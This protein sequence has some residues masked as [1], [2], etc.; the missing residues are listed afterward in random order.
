MNLAKGLLVAVACGALA[1]CGGGGSTAPAPSPAP[2]PSPTP[3]PTPS[4]TPT[5]D[6]SPTPAPTPGPRPTG[7]PN[8]AGAT[9]GS[10]LR[11]QRA[12][13][14]AAVT[15]ASGRVS[16]LQAIVPATL[17]AS[18]MAYTAAAPARLT[19][20]GEAH[21][22][23]SE[24]AEFL[25]YDS[26]SDF[27]LAIVNTA[28]FPAPAVTFG[29]GARGGLCFFAGGLTAT[30]PT[31]TLVYDGTVDG[32]AQ[33]AGGTLRLIRS[34]ADVTMDFAAN[35]GT[36]S[37]VLRGYPDAFAPLTGQTQTTIGTLT[38]NLTVSGTTV[39]ATG[40]TGPAGYTGTVQGE[41]VGATGMAL[42]FQ[43]RNA[44]GDVIWG[45]VAVDG[46]TGRAAWNY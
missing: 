29:Y 42:A 25:F 19:Y 13:T 14:T 33:G 21:F 12:C 7:S 34:S 44:G 17:S 26:L 2:G 39:T 40:V 31:G 9:D 6:P 28:V 8:L 11:L 24:N 27:P 38:A 15:Y 18:T 41:L 36:L 20:E 22:L 46:A 32:L 30:V 37:L 23:S 16:G 43:L 35:S 3:T 5:P 4:P 1:A 10:T 45:A